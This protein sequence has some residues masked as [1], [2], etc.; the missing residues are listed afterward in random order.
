MLIADEWQD[1][2]LIQ[3]GD[4]KKLESWNGISLLRPDP[5]IIWPKPDSWQKFD[6][7]YVRSNSGGGHWE[8]IKKVPASW[9]VSYKKLTFKIQPTN[10][11]HTGL[12]PEQA[13][14]W[15]WIYERISG[16]PLKVLNLFAY[17]GAASIAAA[18]AGAHVTHVDASKG[19]VEWAKEN[20]ALSQLKDKPVR[21]LVDDC[22]KF[23]E[24]EIRRGNKYDAIIM[25]PPSYG[26]GKKGETWK[27][28][29]DLWQLL[30]LCQQCQSD[31]FNFILINSYTTGLSAT[32]LKNLVSSTF[33]FEH[34][35]YQFGE[36]GLEQSDKKIILPCGTFMRWYT[37]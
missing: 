1:Y 4:G 28:E 36:L 26:R 17:T 3:S 31:Q 29:K 16:K 35:Q 10:F 13:V 33:K 18:Q 25:D 27:L 30:D 5:Q 12:F 34:G 11:K 15:D 19:M 9:T 20:L 32:V 6:A 21:F 14:N 8:Y 2:Q 7:E 23:V 22:I 37:N 24:R